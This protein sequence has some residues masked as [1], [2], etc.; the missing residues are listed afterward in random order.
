[1]LS[2]PEALQQMLALP[3]VAM[4]A[5]LGCDSLATDEEASVL[6]LLLRWLE[7]NSVDYGVR[8]RLIKRVR[9]CQLNSTYLLR[10]LP[11]MRA[12]LTDPPELCFLHDYAFSPVAKTHRL[13][14]ALCGRSI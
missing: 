5:L 13:S 1:V 12:S 11:L 3:A 7:R 4:E 10:I 14:A 6:V 8:Q 9:L 2:N